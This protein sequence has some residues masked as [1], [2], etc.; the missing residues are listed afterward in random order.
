MVGHRITNIPGSS[1]Y[2]LGS[3]TAY[4]YEAKARLLGVS[5]DTLNTF[6]AVSDEVVLAMAA[7][8]RKALDADVGIAI[9][10]IAGPGGGTPEKPV[11][12]V[13]FGLSMPTHPDSSAHQ[14]FP[15]SRQEVK[16]QS[17]DFILRWLMERLEE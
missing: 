7:G 1:D 12:L 2:Y 8:V 16:Q 4:A 13:Y 14:I 3:V 17:A 15:G 5:W 11:G 9:S 6:G 10:G